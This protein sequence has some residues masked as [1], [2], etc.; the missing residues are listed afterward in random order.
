MKTL[1]YLSLIVLFSVPS[2]RARSSDIGGVIGGMV[3]GYLDQQGGYY[4]CAYLAAKLMRERDKERVAVAYQNCLGDSGQALTSFVDK[5]ENPE[6]GVWASMGPQC[7]EFVT[8]CTLDSH[9]CALVVETILQCIPYAQWVADLYRKFD[10]KGIGEKIAGLNVKFQKKAVECNETPFL[11]ENIVPQFYKLYCDDYTSSGPISFFTFNNNYYTVKTA[12]ERAYLLDKYADNPAGASYERIVATALGLESLRNPAGVERAAAAKVL[13]VHG[14]YSAPVMYMLLD[15]TYDHKALVRKEAAKALAFQGNKGFLINVRLMQLLEDPDPY[16]R[17]E[18]AV[19]LKTQAVEKNC[20]DITVKTLTG[21]TDSLSGQRYQTIFYHNPKIDPRS[22][23]FNVPTCFLY[24]EQDHPNPLNESDFRNSLGK[25]YGCPEVPTTSS[26][27]F[28]RIATVKDIKD[29]D[30]LKNK[31]AVM[32]PRHADKIM[33]LAQ[34][35]VY[36]GIFREREE[37]TGGRLAKSMMISAL[38]T[39]GRERP[40]IV[41]DLIPWMQSKYPEI[42]TA[43]IYAAA[44]AAID[45]P[46]LLEKLKLP[47]A[48]PEPSVRRAAIG[49]IGEV[50][51]LDINDDIEAFRVYSAGIDFFNAEIFRD[52]PSIENPT[53]TPEW[54]YDPVKE[55]KKYKYFLSGFDNA[56]IEALDLCAYKKNKKTPMVVFSNPRPRTSFFLGPFFEV[57]LNG[58]YA[59]DELRKGIAVLSQSS[60]G[61]PIP[62]REFTTDIREEKSSEGTLYTT[63]VRFSLLDPLLPGKTA[64]LFISAKM[65]NKE[66]VPFNQYPKF[67]SSLQARKIGFRTPDEDVFQVTDKIL[68]ILEDDPAFEV[69]FAAASVLLPY[70]LHEKS[71]FQFLQYAILTRP[72]EQILRARPYFDR[73]IFKYKFLK[74][75]N[76]DEKI[77]FVRKFL[78]LLQQDIDKHERLEN[79]RSAENPSSYLEIPSLSAQYDVLLDLL[80]RNILPKERM[81]KALDKKYYNDQSLKDWLWQR[82]S[83][84]LPTGGPRERFDIYSRVL[85]GNTR[86]NWLDSYDKIFSS[87]EDGTALERLHN[88]VVKPKE[89]EPDDPDL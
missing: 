69:R 51:V 2:P 4:R 65:K 39:L 68:R 5:I 9:T 30:I 41:Q 28:D 54:P 1:L 74:T 36:D 8:R 58:Q 89:G 62:V 50:A 83:T 59:E 38:R 16:V 42:R 20:P 32:V 26:R 57:H 25:T 79:P 70:P 24:K 47:L 73:E 7:K 53:V 29:F 15:A 3:G 67:P 87:P 12:K 82:I 27:V 31:C 43:A 21:M 13:G 81:S 10:N 72:E 80:G 61:L 35:A 66:G 37:T 45:D 71:V 34:Q 77:R 23:E 76:D 86:K 11:P 55:M 64:S 40:G 14:D 56:Y 84:T 63:T 22:L 44:G 78:F 88:V 19:A 6:C 75:M 33:F 48:D 85:Y 60:Q 49:A 17:A 52:C 46:F 18:A